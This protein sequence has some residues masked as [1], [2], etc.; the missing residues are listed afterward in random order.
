MLG[1][2]FL[3]LI[4]ILSKNNVVIVQPSLVQVGQATLEA[5]NVL[6]ALERDQKD[7]QTTQSVGRSARIPYHILTSMQRCSVTYT[8]VWFHPDPCPKTVVHQ[9]VVEAGADGKPS[10]ACWS[11]A[12]CRPSSKQA[13]HKLRLRNPDN[14]LGWQPLS[15]PLNV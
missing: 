7:M 4:F 12:F 8:C 9:H 1:T 13:G 14:N 10:A 2:Y 3:C 6:R 11:W 15:T 5:L